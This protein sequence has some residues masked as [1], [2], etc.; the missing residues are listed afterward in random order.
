ME[1]LTVRTLNTIL[2]VDQKVEVLKSFMKK[3][4]MYCVLYHDCEFMDE[5][6]KPHIITKLHF[7][8]GDCFEEFV[9]Y[10]K[11]N[12]YYTTHF[13]RCHCEDGFNTDENESLTKEQVFEHFVTEGHY[14]LIS[15][16]ELETIEIDS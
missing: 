4:K 6:H 5:Q 10:L 9:Q 8:V 7:T 2:T 13:K 14:N 16:F 11:N 1:S 3:R 15:V 12:N